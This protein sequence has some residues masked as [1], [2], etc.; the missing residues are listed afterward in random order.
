VLLALPVTASAGPVKKASAEDA[1]FRR[2]LAHHY[3]AESFGEPVDDIVYGYAA[4]DLDGDGRKEWVVW[5]SGSSIC[6][7]GGC[8]L[9][10]YVRYESGWR[11]FSDTGLTRLPIKVLKT[12]TNGWLDLA[13]WASGGGIEHP[14]E[15]RLRFTGTAY[16][17]DYGT[18]TETLPATTGRAI[19]SKAAIPLFPTKCRRVN[20][21]PSTFGPLRVASGK[22]GSC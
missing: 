21:V 10:I 9:E 6:G 11:L 12:R 16:E 8:D 3:L 7:S 15:A 2:W 17:G 19:I 18:G 20:E 22:P 1:Q 5:S 4:I 14:Y 13:A